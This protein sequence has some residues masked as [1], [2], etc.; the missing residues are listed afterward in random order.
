MDPFGAVSVTLQ[1]CKL[2][3]ETGPAVM[4]TG[5]ISLSSASSWH[6]KSSTKHLVSLAREYTLIY[7][8]NKVLGGGCNLE[9]S[10]Q[11]CHRFLITFKVI[12]SGLGTI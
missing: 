1:V 2:E 4:P 5:A 3:S 7:R 12:T 9:Y 6:R 8:Y 11:G 10:S